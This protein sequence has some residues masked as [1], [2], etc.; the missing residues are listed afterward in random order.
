MDIT[1]LPGRRSETGP[2]LKNVLAAAGFA[3]AVVTRYRHWDVQF[4]ASADFEAAQLARQ[5]P[6]LVIAKSLGTVIAATAYCLDGFHPAAAVLIGVPF[7]GLAKRE[8]DFLQ[9]FSAAVETLFIQQVADPGGAAAALGEALR[10][11]RGEVV[12]VPGDDHLY[13]DSAAL[14]AIIRDWKGLHP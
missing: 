7:A 12:A 2:W 9:Q 1:A 5:S 6:R 10:L 4:E 8:L 13:A 11:Q 3:E 14:G